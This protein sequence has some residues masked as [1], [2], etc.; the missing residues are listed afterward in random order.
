MKAL[1]KTKVGVG[2]VEYIDIPEPAPKENEVKIK[3]KACGIC[4]TD[5]HVL[6]NTTEL[7]AGVTLGHEF[8]GVVTEVG[9]KVTRFKPGDRVV[10]ATTV[11]KCGQCLYCKTGNE[12]IC[13]TRKGMGRTGNGAFA[14]YI[15]LDQELVYILPDNV[16]FIAGALCEPLACCVHGCVET[17]PILAG[18]VAVVT[19]PGAIGLLAMQLAK[20]QGAKVVLC[21]TS[22]DTERLELGKKLGADVVVNVEVEDA[23]EIVRSMTE[24]LGAD[25]V[26]E[27]S[28][29]APAARLGLDLIRKQGY[30]LQMGLFGKPI[31]LDFQLVTTKELKVFGSVNSKWTTWKTML[32]LLERGLVQ[33][34]PLVTNIYP[35]SEWQKGFTQH[36]RREGIKI[37]LVPDGQEV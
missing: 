24:G 32:K 28:G 21:G 31:E 18:D 15:V 10:A 11:E 17:I 26:V 34:R 13:P 37:V 2:N 12:N 29:A 22:V 33:T 8:T 30:Y 27:C 5:I 7:A 16:D 3:V 14:D 35:L 20:A 1:V 19:G 25:V 6:H 9:A 23:R 36:E 4:G